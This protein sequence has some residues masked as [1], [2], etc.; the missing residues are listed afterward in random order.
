MN[1]VFVSIQSVY[2]FWLGNLVHLHLILI[3]MFFLPFYYM[4]WICFCWSFFFPSSLFLF[5]CGLMTICSVLGLPFLIYVCVFCRF[6]VCSY[7]EVRICLYKIVVSCWSL[8]CRCI[9]TVLPLFPPL[10][11]ISGLGN[12]SVCVDDFL[13]LLYICL[14]WWACL[15]WYFCF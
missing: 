2:V 12:I 6:L 11:M 9:S 7:R 5:S 14:Y 10:L 3:C 15:L 4:F 13:P 8:H 1:R